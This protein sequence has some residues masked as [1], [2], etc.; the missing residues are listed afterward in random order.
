MREAR[1]RRRKKSIAI[2]KLATVLSGPRRA[3]AVVGLDRRT[4]N[5]ELMIRMLVTG[6]VLAI[7]GV[8]RA[9]F[10]AKAGP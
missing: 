8:N 5:P 1:F 7:R 3:A 4:R 6:Y 10:P 2:G 9:S